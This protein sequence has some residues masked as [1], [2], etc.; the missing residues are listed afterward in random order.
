MYPSNAHADAHVGYATNDAKPPAKELENKMERLPSPDEYLN[1]L[2]PDELAA[3]DGVEFLGMRKAWA[4]QQSNRLL[5][6]VRGQKPDRMAHVLSG[7]VAQHATDNLVR[8][9]AGDFDAAK[10]LGPSLD[11]CERGVVAYAMWKAKV[12]RDAFQAYLGYVWAHGHRYVINAACTRRRLAA[13]FSYADFPKPAHLPDTVKVWRGTSLVTKKKAQAGYSWTTDRDVACWFACDGGPP[14]RTP[15]R[16]RTFVLTADV[17]KHEI[18]LSYGG[19]Y[20]SEVVLLKP[21]KSWIDGYLDDW[22]AA[23]ERHMREKDRR[24]QTAPTQ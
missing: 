16:T 10:V 5:S 4:S 2:T 18:A 11:I 23:S 21:P 6:A 15:D 1:S 14:D 3:I 19:R 20:E 22:Q 13:M 8:A 24:H 12:P 7:L 9:F 17:P